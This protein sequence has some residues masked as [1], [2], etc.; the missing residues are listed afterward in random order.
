LFETGYQTR[1]LLF[2]SDRPT[3]KPNP[4]AHKPADSGAAVG[5]DASRRSLREVTLTAVKQ[6]IKHISVWTAN[7]K[8]CGSGL[9]RDGG[10][11]V[12][13]DVEADAPIASRLAP[14]VFYG[15]HRFHLSVLLVPVSDNPLDTQTLPDL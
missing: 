3:I 10:G 7:T 2:S 6:P 4:E 12:N 8:T 1:S 13:L 5:N 14:T 9:A 15:V 11:S